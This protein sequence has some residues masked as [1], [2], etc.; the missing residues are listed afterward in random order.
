[1][2]VNRKIQLNTIKHLKIMSIQFKRSY[3]AAFVQI[4]LA[5]KYDLVVQSD[6]TEANLVRDEDGSKPRYIATLKAIAKD[7]L[8]QLREVFA[9][10]E[11]V[12]I[13]KTNGLF[14]TANIWVKEGV[15]TSLPMKGETVEVII[16][17]VPARDT[18]EP[19]LRV[20]KLARKASGVANKLNITEFF[21]PAG[22]P[23][24]AAQGALAAEETLEHA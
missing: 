12:D 9:T 18:E 16:A 1:M 3:L 8:P 14:M 17:E 13:E 4:L 15:P 21:S 5:G 24:P 20:T 6:V 10:E 2:G 19:V 7:K 11:Q 23:A 22:A